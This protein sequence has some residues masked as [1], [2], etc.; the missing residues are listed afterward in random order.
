MHVYIEVASWGATEDNQ[1][2]DRGVKEDM[3]LH[4]IQGLNELKMNMDTMHYKADI[5]GGT[6]LYLWTCDQ[7]HHLIRELI[8]KS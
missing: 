3:Q 7:I 1:E 6:V 8:L 4:Y 5:L 2:S